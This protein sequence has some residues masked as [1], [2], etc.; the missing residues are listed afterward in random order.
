[1]KQ[2]DIFLFP[3]PTPD[4]PHMGVVL[5]NDGICRNPA[6]DSVNVLP[7]QTVR[8]PGRAKKDNEVY[9]DR[10]DGLD[11]KTLVRCDFVLVFQ[12]SQALEKRGEV[13]PQ[14]IAE[15][16]RKLQEHF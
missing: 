4:D 15:I 5:S 1:M 14:R 2:W 7:C 11:W 13:C 9:L 10:A 6:I 3:H 8:P 12:K 16:R